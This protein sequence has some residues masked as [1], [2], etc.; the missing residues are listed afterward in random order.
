MKRRLTS[1]VLAISLTVLLTAVFD[2]VVPLPADWL[3]LPLFLLVGASSDRFADVA[4]LALKYLR[5]ENRPFVFLGLLLLGVHLWGTMLIVPAAATTLFVYSVVFLVVSSL[6]RTTVEFT[7]LLFV[8]SP[9]AGSEVLRAFAVSRLTLFAS[10]PLLALPTP[11]LGTDGMAAL[12]FFWTIVMVPQFVHIRTL[13]FLSSSRPLLR[14]LIGG[15]VVLDE[16]KVLQTLVGGRLSTAQLSQRTAI[17]E[18]RLLSMLPE[19]ESRWLVERDGKR[20]RLLP[21]QRRLLQMRRA[22]RKSPRY[23][24]QGH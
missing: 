10:S 6:L 7:S 11:G 9:D 3:L 4:P 17:E 12:I 22:T 21:G 14:Y 19:M 8:E 16:L 5:G 13:P 15:T 1:R 18:R 24:K 2:I 20:W 23:G